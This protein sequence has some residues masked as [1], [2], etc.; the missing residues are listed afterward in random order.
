MRASFSSLSTKCVVRVVVRKDAGARRLTPPPARE[1]GS[2]LL[3]AGGREAEG[4]GLYSYLL[5]G[6]PPDSGARERYLKAIE[7]FW[8]VVPDIAALEQYVPRAELNVAYVPVKSAP[9]AT[10]AAGWVLDSYDF[11][12]ARSLLRYVPG[13]HCD[14]PYLLS[15]L[16][17]RS[18]EETEARRRGAQ[19]SSDLENRGSIRGAKVSSSG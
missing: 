19:D 6:A 2:A 7:A 13:A 9:G 12:R 17:R 1:T 16:N 15:V 11:A 4:Y 14:G 3:V 8:A 10:V 5:L 18:Q